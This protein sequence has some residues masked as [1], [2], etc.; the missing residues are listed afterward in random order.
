M[1][2]HSAVT[3]DIGELNNGIFRATIK[4]P[5]K[6]VDSSSI[7]VEFSPSGLYRLKDVQI[8]DGWDIEYVQVA[9]LMI[10]AFRKSPCP[11]ANPA[12]RIMILVRPFWFHPDKGKTE[13]TS[14]GQLIV[15]G[16]VF[17]GF[18]PLSQG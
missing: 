18:K 8:S 4:L 14:D 11:L 1:N 3:A 10:T 16:E 7:L 6:I 2:I 12:V 5:K 17:P 15:T 13:A 9:N